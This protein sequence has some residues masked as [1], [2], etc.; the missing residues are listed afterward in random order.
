MAPDF[1]EANAEFIAER[2]DKIAR[3]IGGRMG[4]MSFPEFQKLMRAPFEQDEWLAIMIGAVI[5][6]GA[7]WIQVLTTLG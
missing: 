6:F 2:Q 4:A 1:M 3:M 7:G 5:G